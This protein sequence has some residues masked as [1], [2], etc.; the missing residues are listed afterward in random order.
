[1]PISHSLYFPHFYILSP[2]MVNAFLVLAHLFQKFR[3]FPFFLWFLIFQN[4]G[5]PLYKKGWHCHPGCHP[6]GG[7]FTAGFYFPFLFSSPIS[8][9][10]HCIINC[11]PCSVP[12]FPPLHLSFLS[13]CSNLPCNYILKFPAFFLFHDVLRLVLEFGSYFIIFIVNN[14]F[15]IMLL[16]TDPV[17][18]VFYHHQFSY[19]TS[20]LFIPRSCSPAATASVMVGGPHR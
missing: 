20:S 11:S 6:R 17:V 16:L 7:S 2:E 18:A 10:S 9:I 4:L 12:A 14:K 19:F 13:T 15:C 1:M 3:L 8:L 5:K